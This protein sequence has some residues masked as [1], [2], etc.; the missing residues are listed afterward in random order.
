MARRTLF[1]SGNPVLSDET[2][3]KAAGV[4]TDETM[5]VRGAVQ[6]SFLLAAVLVVVGV[7]SFMNANPLFIWVGAI[8]GLIAVLI[9][10][11]K[12]EWSPVLAPVYAALEG[13]ALGAI[14]AIY[15][16]AYDGIV[17]NAITLTVAILLAM[18]FLYQTR[19]IKVTD[20]LRSG[21]I[22][23]TTGIFLVYMVDIVLGFFGVNVPYLHS[24]GMIGIGISLFIVGVASLNLLLDFDQFEKGEQY[25]A[26][27]YME[28][29]SALGLL[30]TLVWLYLE[31]LRLLSKLR[32]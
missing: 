3:R 9:A 14:T 28:W 31:I 12:K 20:K 23:A 2:Y 21:I 22:M 29:F 6:K 5:T 8:G 25:G 26:P 30:V 27:K 24:G 13:L 4:A 32:D 19:I 7:W 11:F 10:V 16:A 18:L 15:A 1:S 17:F